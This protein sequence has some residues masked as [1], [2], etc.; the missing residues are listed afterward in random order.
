MKKRI[1]L[2]LCFAMLFCAAC[3]RPEPTSATPAAVSSVMISKIELPFDEIIR[4]GNAAFVGEFLSAERVS[5]FALEHRFRVVSDIGGNLQDQEAYV[6]A[7]AGELENDDAH[8]KP[9]QQYLL[10][11]H[12][13][14]SIFR[15][16]T[17][18]ALNLEMSPSPETGLFTGTAEGLPA[19]QT[20]EELFAYIR[21][22]FPEA[23]RTEPDMPEYTVQ[24]KV[25]SLLNEGDLDYHANNYAVELEDVFRGSEEAFRAA[26]AGREFFFA[27]IEKGQADPGKSYVLT[28]RQSSEGSALFVQTE[29]GNV[30]EAGSAEAKAYLENK[31]YTK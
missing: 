3:T 23:D 22:V 19:Y 13:Y 11:A 31:G 24:L 26:V 16:H 20:N 6:Y 12:F 30:F 27:V 28:V 5:E 29:P 15:T 7:Y 4:R 2:I 9:G 21:K 1:A 14:E 10:L 8:F 18:F 17:V 25:R